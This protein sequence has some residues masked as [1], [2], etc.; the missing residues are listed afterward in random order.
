MAKPTTVAA[1]GAPTMLLQPELYRVRDAATMLGVSERMAYTLIE[2]GQLA[3]VKLPGTGT[4]RSA[5]RIARAD[6]LDFVE[7]RRAAARTAR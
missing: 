2:L 1:T 7:R 4:R 5:V 3:A 6:L